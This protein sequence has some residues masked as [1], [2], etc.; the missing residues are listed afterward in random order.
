M[1][2]LWVRALG[3][4]IGHNC[5]FLG[6]DWIA[7]STADLI[8]VGNDVFASTVTVDFETAEG[9]LSLGQQCLRTRHLF[10]VESGSELGS[11]LRPYAILHI[12]A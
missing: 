3:G 5:M 7:P 4:K 9:D 2:N 11:I 12:D 8:D 10:R 1:C 6:H